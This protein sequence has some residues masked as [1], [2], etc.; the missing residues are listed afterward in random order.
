MQLLSTTTHVE[1]PFIILKIGKWT[2]GQYS[3]D[4]ADINMYGA[5]TTVTFPNMLESLTVDKVNGTV[6][7]YH[8]SLRYG[9]TAG[10]D[11]N[12]LERVF[13]SISDTREI[14]ISYGDWNQPAFTYKEE[15]AIVTKVN[16]SVEFASS[17]LSYQITAVSNSVSLKS[18]LWNFGACRRKPSDVILGLLQNKMY[19]LQSVFTG[20]RDIQKVLEKGLIATDD[21]VVK[22][23]QKSNINILDY[24]SYLVGCMTCSSNATDNPIHDSVYR[25]AIYDDISKEL[26][27]T[28][29]RI[30]KVPANAAGFSSNEVFEVDIGYPT[31]NF[32]TS[33]RVETNDTYSI[34]YHYAMENQNNWTYSMNENGVIVADNLPKMFRSATSNKNY[35]IDENWWTNVTQYPTKAV[36]E[37]RG[38]LRPAILMSYVRVNSYFYGQ[39]YIA[40][41][42]YIITKQ[43]DTIN[44]QG[45]KTTLTLQKIGGDDEASLSNY[46][47]YSSH[48]NT[49]VAGTH[50]SSSGKVHGGGG[51]HIDSKSSTH[52]SSSGTIHGGGG[53]HM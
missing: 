24:L 7:T 38:L 19:G 21:K 47:N 35:S 40:S 5:R 12:L 48:D 2:F 49:A 33:F 9:V 15:T 44:S 26:E 11:P 45:Y 20:M 3:K 52:K 34:L 8:I 50:I 14:T 42:L 25:L 31:N 39:K 16:S 29:F 43:T 32:V 13:G 53:R 46:A 51:R 28:Y 23:Q 1:S 6:N 22:I 37:I 4:K 36:L 27:G 30:I 10:D 41:G 17:K 18:T